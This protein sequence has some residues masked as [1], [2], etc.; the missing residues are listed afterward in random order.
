[1]MSK[2]LGEKAKAKENLIS[3]LGVSL[4]MT[5]FFNLKLCSYVEHSKNHK[6]C[7]TLT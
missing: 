7:T 3:V 4:Y 6:H 1:M 5:H 2:I